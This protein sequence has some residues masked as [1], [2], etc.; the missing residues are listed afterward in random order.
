MILRDVLH[1]RPR[2]VLDALTLAERRL[3]LVASAAAE[4]VTAEPES[5]VDGLA[6]AL[7]CAALRS[8]PAEAAGSSPGRAGVRNTT[9]ETPARDETSTRYIDPTMSGRM[10]STVLP[11]TTKGWCPSRTIGVRPS[12]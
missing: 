12:P 3:L 11:V 4:V 1:P 5:F 2:E 8:I 6:I 10:T 9:L 7:A